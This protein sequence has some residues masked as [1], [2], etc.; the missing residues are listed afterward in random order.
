MTIFMLYFADEPLPSR[1]D[2]YEEVT[3]QEDYA[4]DDESD[5]DDNL[6]VPET[7]EEEEPYEEELPARGRTKR[8][9]Q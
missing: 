8:K 1:D 3:P 6:D 4:Y 5:F 7:V 9:K 2:V